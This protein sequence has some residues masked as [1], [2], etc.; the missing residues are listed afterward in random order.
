MSKRKANL[1]FYGNSSISR[2]IM[3]NLIND[4]EKTILVGRQVIEYKEKKFTFLKIND[5]KNFSD[6]ENMFLK[7]KRIKFFDKPVH[8]ILGAYE[9]PN[10]GDILEMNYKEFTEQ[11]T[12]N[13]KIL[14]NLIYIFSKALMPH[15]TFIIFSGGGIGGDTKLKHA[16]SYLIMKVV[17]NEITEICSRNS[18]FIENKIRIFA[19]SPGPFSSPLSKS[20]KF[21]DITFSKQEVRNNTDKLI[22]LVNFLLTKESISLSGSILSARYDKLSYLKKL[23]RI[24]RNNPNQKNSLG[25]HSRRRKIDFK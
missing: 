7:L 3:A 16:D 25:L 1:L 17:G 9:K 23:I 24:I 11:I 15:S 14:H 8:I 21:N 19:V 22:K 6:V 18:Y 12:S 13:L 20:F 4:Y 5:L 10:S 2:Y